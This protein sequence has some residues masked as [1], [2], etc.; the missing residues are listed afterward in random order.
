MCGPLGL[1][2]PDHILTTDSREQAGTSRDGPWS[3]FRE[4]PG[5][6]YKRGGS[7]TSRVP[8]S[9]TGSQGVRGSNPL[10]STRK[11]SG[12]NGFWLFVEDHDGCRNR[13]LITFD[14]IRRGHDACRQRH[15]V[16]RSPVRPRFCAA[17]CADTTLGEG[18]AFARPAAHGHAAMSSGS[19]CVRREQQLVPRRSASTCTAHAE[20]ADRRC[21]TIC[22]LWQQNWVF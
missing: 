5:R 14:H 1:S 17:M 15:Q 18:C 16:G 6:G 2:L 13:R 20:C 19:S 9:L 21:P 10:S 11:R 3:G 22:S 7:G 12:T 4:T 8:L